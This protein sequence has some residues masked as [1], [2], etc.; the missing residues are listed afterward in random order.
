MNH[1]KETISIKASY[2]ITKVS[3]LQVKYYDADDLEYKTEVPTFRGGCAEEFLNFL[4]E[5]SDLCYKVPY[6][7]RS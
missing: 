4:T 2:D 3:S 7:T 6:E 5:F 1:T